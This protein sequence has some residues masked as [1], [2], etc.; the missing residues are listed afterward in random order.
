MNVAMISL[1]GIIFLGF[2]ARET[3]SEFTQVQRVYLS[4]PHEAREHIHRFAR[5]LVMLIF[6]L[7]QAWRFVGGLL[8]SKRR[9]ALA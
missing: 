5:M 8:A 2:F 9:P 7:I 4:L 1:L 6:G 3:A